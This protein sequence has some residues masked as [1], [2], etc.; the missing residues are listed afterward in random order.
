MYKQIDKSGYKDSK[1]EN[2]SVL[3]TLDTS[4]TN[5]DK[6]NGLEYR[7]DGCDCMG[8]GCFKN[9]WTVVLSPAGVAF[10]MTAFGAAAMISLVDH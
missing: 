2:K 7:I 10:G 8:C 3:E 1:T 6:S 9:A 4:S 5:I